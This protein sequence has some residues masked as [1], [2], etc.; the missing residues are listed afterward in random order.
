MRFVFD[1]KIFT[2][3][4]KLQEPVFLSA[5]GEILLKGADENLLLFSWITC[6]YELKGKPMKATEK[7]RIYQNENGPRISTVDQPVIE[8]DGL[9]FKDIDGSGELKVYSDWRLPAE[10]RAEALVKDMSLDEKLGQLFVTS[11]NPADHTEENVKADETGL[12]DET[13]LKDMNIFAGYEI[14]G[15][16][17][18]IRKDKMRNFI[19]RANPDPETL[20]NW[21]NQLQNTAEKDDHFIPVLVTT[22]S[23]NENGKAV[24]GMNDAVGVF[25]AW[26]GTLGIASAILGD[27][28]QIASDFGNAIRKE[29]NAAGLKKGYMYMADAV[30][31]PRWQRIYGTFGESPELIADIFDRLIPAVQG[32][33]NGITTDGVALTVKHWPGGGARENGFDPHYKEGQWNV[34]ATEDSLR[35]Y[36]L[37]GFMPAIAHKAA[38]IMPYYAKPSREKSA[39]QF[40]ADGKPIEWIPVGFA[41]N[42][43][44]IQDLLRDQYR[45]EGYVNSDSGIIDNMGWGVE[46]LD[47]PERIALAVHNG[48]DLISE[49]YGNGY[50][51][52]AYERRTNG[53]YDT[54]PIPEGYTL[55]DI[56]LSDEDIDRA[57]ARTLKEKFELGMFEDPFRDPQAS[58][59]AITE[60]EDWQTAMDVHRK[61]VVLLKNIDN[62]LP[63]TDTADKT[64][65]IRGFDQ[66]A[67]GSVKFTE[68]VRKDLAEENVKTTENPEEADVA[69]LM[70]SPN[71]GNYFS[72]TKGLL[73]IDLCENKTVADFSE[74]GLPLETT[75]EETTVAGINEAIEIAKAIRAKGGKAIFCVNI[76]LPWLMGNVEPYADALLAGFDTYEKALLDMIFGRF[77]PT[78]KLPMTLPK[79]DEVIAV[80]EK[81]VCIS[82]NDVPGFAKDAHMPESLKDENGKA[83]AYR[84]ENGNY[85][86]FGF[87][88]TY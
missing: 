4:W 78:G 72:A 66:T 7:I 43:Y 70:L 30:T 26:P 55:E 41:F 36:H 19:L 28:L 14:P 25:P 29:W 49:S 13:E 65:F 62:T 75:H 56:T 54:H 84:D 60:S 38:S 17:D 42:N 35:K 87:G 57:A 88:L 32:S 10:K 18:S 83:Y 44:F 61:S 31:D 20:T 16:T 50:A 9:T 8:K 80:N 51:K 76:T 73:E 6:S 59:E 74:E 1:G 3:H 52:E 45:F 63:Q 67:E 58:K 33:E 77:V 71:S 79:N 81:G 12:L 69:I 22:N 86:E 40:G 27:D 23:R 21:L 64:Y 2:L 48:V 68:K 34:Y 37:P 47:R 11:R 53:Y 24:F 15:T 82:P 5:S 39:D 46:H 85:Y